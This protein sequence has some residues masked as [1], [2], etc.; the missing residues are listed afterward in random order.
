MF[1]E[2]GTSLLELR[3]SQIIT[4]SKKMVLDTKTVRFEDKMTNWGE[5]GLT[6]EPDQVSLQQ[7]GLEYSQKS[8]AG[9]MKEKGDL[10][11]GSDEK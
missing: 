1:A 7:W 6:L 11:V 8:K 3:G 10:W 2:A 9:V 5:G 4:F